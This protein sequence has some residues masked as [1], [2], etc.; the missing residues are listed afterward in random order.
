MLKRSNHVTEKVSSYL[1]GQLS[2]DERRQV[3]E[4]LK[5]CSECQRELDELKQTVALLRACPPAK[6]PR[7]F[8][9]TAEM[10]EPSNVLRLWV[11]FAPALTAVAAVLL[12]LVLFVDLS[13]SVGGGSAPL[14][15]APAMEKIA[16]GAPRALEA[17]QGR[18]REEVVAAPSLASVEV[19]A[20]E[21]T[22]AAPMRSLGRHVE[23]E[24]SEEASAETVPGVLAEPA[25]GAAEAS[26]LPGSRAPQTPCP[27]EP[28]QITEAPSL[29]STPQAEVVSTATRIPPLALRSERPIHVLR[30]VEG[31]LAL[32]MLVGLG[33]TV[34]EKVRGV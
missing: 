3:E 25:A 4:H 19:P 14:A 32:A 31:I 11:R 1:D 28:A 21:A 29:P 33:L 10:A 9:L 22:E 34:L 15:A 2:V 13:S 20:D 12:A 27:S 18:E 6:L 24:K 5:N 17:P 7:S 26:A 8:I 30:V 16:T 23:S